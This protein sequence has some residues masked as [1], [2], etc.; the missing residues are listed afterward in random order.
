MATRPI[1]TLQAA[2]DAA[3]AYWGTTGQRSASITVGKRPSDSQMIVTA[4]A[5][6][7]SGELVRVGIMATGEPIGADHPTMQR[8][9]ARDMLTALTAMPADIRDNLAAAHAAVFYA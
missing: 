7:A 5:S 4:L 1:D 8:G 3:Y 2:Q 9:I 6:K